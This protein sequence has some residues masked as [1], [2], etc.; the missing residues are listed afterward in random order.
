MLN[1]DDKIDRF[2]K[3]RFGVLWDVELDECFVFDV[4]IRECWYK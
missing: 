3:L 4:E 2:L 1:G